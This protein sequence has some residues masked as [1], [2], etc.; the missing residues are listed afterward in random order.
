VDTT[1]TVIGDHAT[2]VLPARPARPANSRYEFLDVLGEGAMGIVYRAR[3]LE[4]HRIVAVKTIAPDAIHAADVTAVIH[5]LYQEATAAARL[6]HP[7]IVTIYD[8]NASGGVPYVVMEYVKGRTVAELLTGGPLPPDKAVHV[9]V[10]VCHALQYAHAQGVVHRDV[11]STNI[12]VDDAWHVKLT[13]FGVARVVDKQSTQTGVMVG[14]PAYMSPEQVRGLEADAQSDLFSL[15]VVLY[16]AL[17]GARPFPGDDVATVLDEVLR[18]EPLSP[19]ERNGAVS[20]ALDAVVM[21]AMSKAPRDRYPDA[22]AFADALTQA[23]AVRYRAAVGAA[24]RR[25]L[26]A[27]YRH[28]TALAFSGL[29]AAALAVA[30]FVLPIGEESAHELVTTASRAAARTVDSAAPPRIVTPAG[31]GAIAVTT[32]PSVDVFLDGAFRG[33]VTRNRLVLDDVPT[34]SRTVTLRLAERERTFL[35]TVPPGA[36]LAVRYMFADEVPLPPRSERAAVA[37]DEPPPASPGETR[38]GCLSVNAVPFATV[39]ID[40][41]RVGDTPRACLRIGTGRHR[42]YFESA[43]ERS[44]EEVIVV[45]ERH[46][47]DNPLRVSYDFQT[48]QFLAR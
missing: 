26:Q 29:G 2:G 6:T 43:N 34:G 5:R 20:P 37:G 45:A 36:T 3:D 24:L 13:D 22:A 30:A 40:G 41:R 31:T 14:T 32:N 11:K 25:G 23:A 18:L 16:E 9:V 21:R 17:V 8:V 35:E 27:A 44:P 15:G 46:T 38:F 47:S 12:M 39:H 19:R 1:R 7:G 10:Q 48:R 28:G 33:R 42:L 4:L